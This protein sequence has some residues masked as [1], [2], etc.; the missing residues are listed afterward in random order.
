MGA[1]HIAEFW[2]DR[3][4]RGPAD[5]FRL[6][7]DKITGREGWGEVSAAKLIAAIDERRRLPLDRFINALASRRSARRRRGCS[8]ATTA[9]SLPGGGIWTRRRTKK[10]ARAGLLDVQASAPTWPPDIIGFLRRA[11]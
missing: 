8:R 10:P 9:R 11:T 5:I 2:E 6:T 1:K 7:A 4:I 3:L